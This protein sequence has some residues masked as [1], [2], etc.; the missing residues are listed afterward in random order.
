MTN[1]IKK[2]IEKVWFW[3]RLTFGQIAKMFKVSA[4]TISR[5][6]KESIYY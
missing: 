6:I 2:E 1:G 3:N 4:S 5:V